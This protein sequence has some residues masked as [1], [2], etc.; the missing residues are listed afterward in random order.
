LRKLAWALSHLDALL[1]FASVEYN[2]KY[3]R[4][5]F[6]DN[7]DIII[8]KGRHPVVEQKCDTTFIPNDVK[9]TDEESLWIITGPNMG[10]K[11]TYLR[12]V[13]LMS[14]MAQCGSFVPAESV[15]LSILDRIFTRIG[16]GDNVAEGKSTFLVE[17]EETSTICTQAT[18]NSLVILDEVGRG[19]STFDGL[20]L[21]QAVVEHIYKNVQARCLF[22]TH[23]HEL[24][25]L[26][27][28]FPGIVSYYAA[29][30]KTKQGI[31]FLYTI[32]KGV[33]DGSFGIE[34]AKLAQLPDSIIVRAKEVLKL[35]AASE[36]VQGQSI[37][38]SLKIGSKQPKN[39]SLE[40]ENAQLKGKI[41][42]LQEKT[43]LLEGINFGELS[44]KQ[45]FDLL[46]K[47][48]EKQ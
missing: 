39:I 4:P 11:S 17:M 41:Q 35:L 5:T 7:R 2:N 48:K 29:S 47:F 23:Y 13:A 10:G 44:P 36:E 42:D 45:A 32:I 14:I 21:A 43:E 1:G 37:A 26:Q 46:W 31:L 15:N 27:D 34:V 40:Q 6:N 18:H 3:V 24:T 12:Q 30:K 38:G 33:A 28:Y 16:S 8:Q 9:L 25:M 20:A 22:A 19:T